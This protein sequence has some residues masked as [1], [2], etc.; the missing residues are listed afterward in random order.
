MAASEAAA[1][2]AEAEPACRGDTVPPFGLPSNGEEE[3]GG[4]WRDTSA[5]KGINGGIFQI[6]VTELSKRLRC[7]LCSMHYDLDGSGV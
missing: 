3:E 6:A 5:L 1:A 7:E 2:E 4:S